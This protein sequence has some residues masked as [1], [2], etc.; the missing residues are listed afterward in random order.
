MASKLSLLGLIGLL[1]PVA[2]AQSC[3]VSGVDFQDGGAYCQNSDS[4]DPFTF[5]QEFEGTVLNDCPVNLRA[6][7][8]TRMRR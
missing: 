1:A 5:V 2:L 6:N 3:V 8:S 4:T 7:M